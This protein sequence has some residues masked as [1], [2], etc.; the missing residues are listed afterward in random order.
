[1]DRAWANPAI[2]SAQVILQTTIPSDEE[3]E[4]GSCITKKDHSV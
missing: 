4:K 3:L 1:M 2:D